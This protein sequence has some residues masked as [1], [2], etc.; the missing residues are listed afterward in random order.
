M[1]VAA[2]PEKGKANRAVI[3]LLSLAL[4]LPRSAVTIVSGESSEDKVVEIA[5]DAGSVR[6][7]LE[8]LDLPTKS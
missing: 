1:A 4:N 3:E 6:D 7:I 8:K 2:A 5:L